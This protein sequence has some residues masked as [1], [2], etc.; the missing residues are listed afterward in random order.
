MIVY[1]DVL[2]KFYFL[3]IRFADHVLFFAH[4][5][6]T[7]WIF[8]L[9]MTRCVGVWVCASVFQKSSTFCAFVLLTCRKGQGEE[10]RGKREAGRK[11]D[12]TEGA[13]VAG[14][15]GDW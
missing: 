1:V 4:S 15:E 12:A 8:V 9:V 3:C 6:P 10:G 5:S 2:Q 13:E 7:F 14:R 11:T